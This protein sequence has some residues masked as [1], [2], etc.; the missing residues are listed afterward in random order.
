[1]VSSSTFDNTY[2]SDILRRPWV[3]DANENGQHF[4]R[5]P[6]A[7]TIMLNTDMALAFDIGD[8]ATVNLNNCR[9]GRGGGG[10]RGNNCPNTAENAETVATF[11]NNQQTWFNEF[12]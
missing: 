8:D 5:D 11:A 4:W 12:G 3:R 6:N 10:Q 2:Y 1:M 7:D 9:A